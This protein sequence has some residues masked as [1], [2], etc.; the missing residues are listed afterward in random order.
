LPAAKI[1]DNLYFS[2]DGECSPRLSP[3][4]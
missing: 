3:G 1:V 4:R 2:R